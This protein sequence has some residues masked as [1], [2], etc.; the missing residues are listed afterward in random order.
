MALSFDHLV[1]ALDTQLRRPLPG[2]EAQQA[3]APR[4]EAGHRRPPTEDTDCT[5]A[6]VL[7]LLYPDADGVPTVLLT[8]R[9]SDLPHHPGQISFPGGRCEGTETPGDTALREAH[10]EVG[11][12]PDGCT[13][14]GPLTPLYIPPSGF[15]AHPF[16]AVCPK[17]PCVTVQETE[18]QALLPASLPTLLNPATRTVETWTLHGRPIDVPYYAISGHTVWGATAMMLAELLAVVRQSNAPHDAHS[19]RSRS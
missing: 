9:R 10:E 3:M 14:L 2:A 11:I 18:V 12:A 8:V 15:C 13:V 6:G 16:V 4:Y 19:A 17:E 7:A 5:D 1:A